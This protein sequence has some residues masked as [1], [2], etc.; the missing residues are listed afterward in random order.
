MAEERRPLGRAALADA[1]RAAGLDPSGL[2]EQR[3]LDTHESGWLLPSTPG[4]W[5]DDWQALRG[6]VGVTGRWPLALAVWGGGPNPDP[7]NRLEFGPAEE[8]VD[9]AP[10]AIVDRVERA[11][12]PSG[13]PEHSTAPW[14]PDDD[15]WRWAL[16]ET[17]ARCGRAPTL[18]DLHAVLGRVV[19]DLEGERWLLDWEL[20]HPGGAQEDSDAS[21]LDWFVPDDVVLVLLPTDAPWAS[22]AYTAAYECGTPTPDTRTAVARRWHQ[23]YAAV[24]A[25]NWG[26]MWQLVVD[27]PPAT[28]QAA[29]PVAAESARLWPDTTVGPGVSTRGHARDLVGRN[30]WFLHFRP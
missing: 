23:E 30:T 29:W 24:P 22:F 11:Q 25:A 16:E 21:Y 12:P 17:Q 7:F 5:F 19:A 4:G 18:E 10:R 15:Y 28:V 20:A 3:V 13:P 14:T 1:V 2:V 9:L 27:R 6:A 8:G 26:T